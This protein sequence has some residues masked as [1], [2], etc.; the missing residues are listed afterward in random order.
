MVPLDVTDIIFPGL[1]LSSTSLFKVSVHEVRN[2]MLS[3]K[4]NAVLVGVRT[5]ALYHGSRFIKW[6][7][8]ALFVVS[9]V[10]IGAL[11]IYS[12]GSIRSTCLLPSEWVCCSVRRA[13]V[14]SSFGV[15]FKK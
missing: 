9:T 5:Y 11:L 6:G 8:I 3:N 15:P 4:S 12:D 2:K 7:I 10:T 1:Q 13:F 14:S